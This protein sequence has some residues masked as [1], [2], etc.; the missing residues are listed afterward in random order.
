[1][2]SG[3]GKH[4]RYNEDS[5]G[6]GG[7]GN[8]RRR[9]HRKSGWAGRRRDPGGRGRLRAARRCVSSGF[10]PCD[11]WWGG[12]PSVWLPSWSQGGVQKLSARFLRPQPWR[13]GNP[14]SNIPGWI[15]PGQPLLPD[16]GLWPEGWK[17][18]T[19]RHRPP[20][21][22][23]RLRAASPGNSAL[24]QWAPEGRSAARVRRQNGEPSR[25][26]GTAGNPAWLCWVEKV[27]LGGC[28]ANQGLEG[29]PSEG[30]RPP[31]LTLLRRLEGWRSH[32]SA[33]RGLRGGVPCAPEATAHRSKDGRWACQTPASGFAPCRAWPAPAPGVTAGGGGRPR[34]CPAASRPASLGLFL[35]GSPQDQFCKTR[36]PSEAHTCPPAPAT[37]PPR[38]SPSSG[39][40]A[41]P[42]TPRA[43]P[44]LPGLAGCTSR[45]GRD[46]H[47]RGVSSVRRLG[48]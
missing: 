36:R 40:V 11:F 16:T 41:R 37:A 9:R 23:L 21:L 33:R 7:D 15:P 46:A 39:R 13:E 14:G 12:S 47:G 1:M 29:V 45:D 24:Q 32:S 17:V 31:G 6:P 26:P 3:S 28:E 4:H 30:V 27:A 42:R 18:L 38:S 43:G 8:G 19:A 48:S 5:G 22:R 20:A 2:S 34:P 25:P 10:L 35:H 44:L